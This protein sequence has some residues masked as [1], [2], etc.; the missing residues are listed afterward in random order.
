MMKQ[1]KVAELCAE[2]ESLLVDFKYS[3]DS[4]RRYRKVFREFAD[5][6]GDCDYSQSKGTD[7]LVWKFQMIGGFVATG[8]HSKNE[9]YYFRVVRS[10]AEYYNFGTIFRRHDFKGEVVW[11]EQFK[12]ATEHFLQFEIEYGHSRGYYC[13]CKNTIK[14]LILFLDSADVHELDG[15]TP[16]HI[17]RYVSTLVGLAPVTIAERLSVLRQ[18]FKYAYF[19]GYAKK[20]LETYIPRA[21]Q[22]IRTKLPTVWSEEE[23]ERLIDA[24]DTTT[25][26]GKRD[27]AIILL[28]ARLGIRI[29]D[30]LQ[31]KPNDID[32]GR[33]TITVI[34]SKT[35]ENLSLPLP[36]D[37]G[38]AVIDYL[39]NGRP[40]TKY[41]HIFVVHSSPYQGFPMQSTIRGRI[42]KALYRA[43]ITVDKAKRCGWHS[44]RHS[45]A[46]NLLQNDVEV[47]VISD[48]LGHADPQIASHYL[49]VDKK[50]LSKC[51]LEV[52]VMDHVRE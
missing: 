37:A 12:D 14:D 42:M 38:W 6:A 50:G 25:P 16:G 4:M 48:I 31:L 27:Y 2:L 28:A 23:I 46:T 40:V 44:F 47:S 26:I 35:K 24:V 18:Y 33:K 9:M 34:Q 30:I 51:C 52:E 7:F 5:F 19:H 8:E 41:P 22:R 15:I 39:K 1:I 13:H 36:D 32:W 29:G 43:D 20:P 45:L 49:R 10:L 11:P 21:P 3:E 17:S